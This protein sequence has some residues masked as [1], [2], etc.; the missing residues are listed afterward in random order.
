MRDEKQ[1]WT[2]SWSQPY[3]SWPEPVPQTPSENEITDFTQ[4]R[5]VLARI[6][7]K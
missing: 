4:A 1:I 7:A 6:M 5:E 3:A 2:I